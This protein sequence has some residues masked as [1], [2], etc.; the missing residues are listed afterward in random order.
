[1]AVSRRLHLYRS[2]RNRLSSPRLRSKRLRGAMRDGL[3]S[4]SDVPGAGIL[5]SVEPYWDAG[6][7]A[8]AA[9]RVAA[10]PLQVRPACTCWSAVIPLRSTVGT[11]P[12]R[13][14]VPAQT[15]FGLVMLKHG[16]PPAT[17]PLSYL[18]LTAIQGR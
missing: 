7:D 2:L 3:W 8:N 6:H 1:M 13:K 4:S 10:T 16:T 5:I 17:R 11:P 15:V 14:D 9:V 12:L 18:Q